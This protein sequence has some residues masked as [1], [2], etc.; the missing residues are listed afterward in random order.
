MDFP[1]DWQVGLLDDFTWP[2]PP[3][4]HS[5]TL[6]GQ[7]RTT[8][9]ILPTSIFHEQPWHSGWRSGL[10]PAA[11]G[12]PSKRL[13]AHYQ[14]WPRDINNGR[15]LTTSCW[16][17]VPDLVVPNNATVLD[18]P[19]RE[20]LAANSTGCYSR[21]AIWQRPQDPRQPLVYRGGGGQPPQALAT[22][23]P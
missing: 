8:V 9:R 2:P 14:Y 13:Q 21:G 22:V 4:P 5:A 23:P 10:R 1:P 20:S 6:L 19:G 3:W 7:L 16:M 18:R 17:D 12:R 11:A 15:S